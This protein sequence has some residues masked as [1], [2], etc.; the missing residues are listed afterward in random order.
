MGHLELKVSV[1]PVECELLEG[2]RGT[3]TS[4]TSALANK[5]RSTS[6]WWWRRLLLPRVVTLTPEAASPLK[7]G[8]RQDIPCRVLWGWNETP[9][10][11]LLLTWH[12]WD[13]EGRCDDT[14]EEWAASLGRPW[15][16]GQRQ[17]L[18]GSSLEQLRVQILAPT[19]TSLEILPY[20]ASAASSKQWG[21]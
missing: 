10:E 21:K 9:L 12:R 17:A 1:P 19:F 3:F 2:R 7:R 16:L 11:S 14:W 5:W 8:W 15:M 6:G 20:W 18:T 13:V 4:V